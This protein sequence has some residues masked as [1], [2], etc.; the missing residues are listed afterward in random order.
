MTGLSRRKVVLR[1]NIGMALALTALISNLSVMSGTE[2]SAA[3]S[4]NDK[5]SL[6]LS[7]PFVQGSHVT[8]P[9]TMTETFDAMAT[10]SNTSNNCPASSA[11]GSITF[12]NQGCYVSERGI[13]GGAIS[14]GSSPVV[15]GSNAYVVDGQGFV[16]GPA[17]VGSNF[18]ATPFY[19]SGPE[20]STTFNFGTAVKYVGLWWSGGNDANRVRFFSADDTLIAE[21]SSA[22]ITALLG[23]SPNPFPGTATVSTKVGGSHVRGLYFGN[24]AQYSSTAPTSPAQ[25]TGPFIFGYLN[26]F[27]QGDLAV[28]KMQVSGPG[29]EFDNLTV[30]TVDQQVLDNMVLVS[31][32]TVPSITWNPNTVLALS[33]SPVT[34]SATPTGS[35]PGTFTYSV[36]NAGNT[37]CSVNTNT[38][39]I[40]YTANGNCAIR[41]SLAPSNTATAFAASK[42]VTFNISSN[43]PGVPGA[44]VATAGDGR[45]TI[46]ITPPS[47]GGAPDSYLVTATPGGATCQVVVPATS[48]SITGLNNGTTYTFIASATNTSATSMPSAASNAVVPRA[49]S[50]APGQTQAPAQYLGPLP[51]SYSLPCVPEGLPTSVT[52]FGERL[53][54]IARASVNGQAIAVGKQSP[55]SVQLLLPA[56]TQA[57]YDI[58][59]EGALGKV[60]HQSA[61]SVCAKPQDSS[62][63]G[64]DTTNP[65]ES[66]TTSFFVSKRFTA[67]KGD[68]APVFRNNRLAIEAFVRA[69]P[70]L[71]SITCLGS[72][73]GREVPGSDLALAMARAK[74]AC[75]VVR[76]LVP[77][78]QIRLAAS[79][80]KGVGP[81]HRAVTLFGVGETRR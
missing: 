29:F 73:S 13:Y 1:R 70:G 8:G 64:F 75:D 69:N 76:N 36:A 4:S 57:T 74:N 38:G 35:V 17:G 80:G 72:T 33:E 68:R 50:A 37:G 61:I 27:L 11:V 49:A 78:I 28:T 55:E 18:M 65:V 10:G 14:S 5:I 20:R 47:S 21:L 30:S 15:G 32:K 34:P 46:N 52:L 59:Y 44:P 77:G 79:V 62:S 51:V 2:S 31:E 54:T 12:T 16:T 39:V 48:C 66:A 60:I 81:F 58:E 71:T 56:L 40:T 53:Q 43:P 9:G 42:V 63:D 3:S 7:A 26:L 23:N 45:A 6:Y 67:F 19:N 25:F 41:A 24:P 22:D